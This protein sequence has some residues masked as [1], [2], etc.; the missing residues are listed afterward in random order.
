MSIQDNLK[1]A[2]GISCS[3][4]D[5]SVRRQGWRASE[6]DKGARL[7]GLG[8]SRE[9]DKAHINIEI[10]LCYRITDTRNLPVTRLFH[11]STK[12]KAQPR[13]VMLKLM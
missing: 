4:S 3:L 12:K 7:L 8:R 13:V 6:E 2:H 9:H 5:S 10:S 11:L 1:T